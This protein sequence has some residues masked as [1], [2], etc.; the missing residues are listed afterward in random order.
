[1]N[2]YLEMI[3]SALLELIVQP[4]YW[5]G[6][7][8][9][10]MYYRRQGMLERKLFHIRLHGYGGLAARSLLGGLCAGAAVSLIMA[11]LGFT[12][13]P[14][15]AAAVWITALVLL[16]FRIR[17][18]NFAY[19][20]GALGVLQFALS[21]IP[22]LP[23]TGVGGSV[24]GAIQGLNIPALLVLAALLHLTES[25]LIALQGK[26][27]A[28]PTYIPGK[29]GRPVGAYVLRMLWLAPT[30]LLVPAEGGAISLPWHPP[31][32]GWLGLPEAA[33]YTLLSLPVMFGM[34]E[35]TWTQLPERKASRTALRGLLFGG[36]LLILAAGAVF[37]PS[38]TVIVAAAGIVLREA[39]IRDAVREEDG[40]PSLYAHSG[41]GL[42]ILAVQPGSPAE[43]M[44][45]LPGETMLKVN[46]SLVGT[47][48]QMHEAL[49]INS[50]FCKLEV[51]NRSGESKFLQRPIYAGDH[52]QLGFVFA[53][54]D[55]SLSERPSRPLSLP[56]LWSVHT[57][58]GRIEVE[59]I[60]L[61]SP[62]SDAGLPSADSQTLTAEEPLED[63]KSKA[64]P[65]ASSPVD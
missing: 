45:I 42:K 39:L 60:L 16:A 31:L 37:W 7:L 10:L 34:Q 17:F 25:A 49:R 27:F 58:P 30:L 59:P 29:R 52:H 8:I 20:V 36:V 11:G 55:A 4:F 63:R 47:T 62:A 56:G 9:L 3:L 38:I 48:Q 24:L 18:A 2:E 33:G 44:G 32:N 65:A 54:D 1:M 51:Q 50:A 43:D 6:L 64:S 28:L 53:P 23:D 13:T 14:S 61:A 5:A 22:G 41:R 46:G 15:G 35:A 40:Q 12:L 21:W 57:E 19:A 26:H